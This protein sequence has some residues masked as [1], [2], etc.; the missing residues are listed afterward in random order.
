MRLNAAAAGLLFAACVAPDATRTAAPPP[1]GR[2]LVVRVEPFVNESAEAEAA[3]LSEPLRL[4]LSRLLVRTGRFDEAAMDAAPD[5]VVEGALTDLVDED[6]SG[7]VGVSLPDR[8]RSR[9]ARVALRVLVRDAGGR[10]VVRI[11]SLGE[12]VEPGAVPLAVPPDRALVTGAFWN[13]PFGRA[14]RQARPAPRA[15]G[16]PP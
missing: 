16:A 4:L 11:A 10:E 9:R 1:P 12:A 14:A 3:R 6:A 8:E 15:V 7:S 13:E 5:L 2:R